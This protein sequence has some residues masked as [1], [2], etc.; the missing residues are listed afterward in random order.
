MIGS[1]Q[2]PINETFGLHSQQWRLLNSDALIV[3]TGLFPI[4]GFLRSII[5]RELHSFASFIWGV[6]TWL[7]AI[8][9]TF[10]GFMVTRAFTR[11]DDYFGLT[12]RGKIYGI[13][14]L[15]QHFSCNPIQRAR[16]H[17]FLVQSNKSAQFRSSGCF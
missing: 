15:A 16:N 14:Y 1:L 2:A 4:W 10:G 13:L 3:A 7:S 8:L 9:Q 5:T 6:T 17:V 12:L 11:I